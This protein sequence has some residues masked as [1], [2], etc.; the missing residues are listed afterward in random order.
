MSWNMNWNKEELRAGCRIEFVSSRSD[1]FDSGIEF[2]ATILNTIEMGDKFTS[3]LAGTFLIYRK[4]GEIWRSA[5]GHSFLHV[6]SSGCKFTGWD[7]EGGS[8]EIPVYPLTW[9]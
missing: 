6:S 4:D 2:S 1:D 7:E 5:P 8:I 3:S 9:V